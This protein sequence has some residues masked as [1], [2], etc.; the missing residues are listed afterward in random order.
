VFRSYAT[1]LL[2]LALTGA[3]LAQD[4]S[5]V[6]STDFASGAFTTYAVEIDFLTRVRDQGDVPAVL[7]DIT[8]FLDGQAPGDVPAWAERARVLELRAMLRPIMQEY[9]EARQDMEEALAIH[10]RHDDPEAMAEGLLLLAES[11]RWK[12]AFGT[13]P[14]QYA[15]LDAVKAARTRIRQGPDDVR[16][17][18]ERIALETESQSLHDLGLLVDADRAAASALADPTCDAVCHAV[19][20][21]RR[22]RIAREQGEDP[23]VQAVAFAEADAVISHE[24]WRQGPPGLVFLG[25][26]LVMHPMFRR[27]VRHVLGGD[28][29]VP[30]TGEERPHP[31]SPMTP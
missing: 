17:D 10:R 6:A 20:T 23:A 28:L 4:L 29:G 12:G 14:E 30:Y 5:S 19:M 13:V 11:R 22:I 27:R 1:F 24:A 8:S 31:T 21:R 3:S 7:A 16:G 26:R 9:D 15:S 18:L 25:S 2:S